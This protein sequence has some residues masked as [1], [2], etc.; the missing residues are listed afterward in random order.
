VLGVADPV[1]RSLEGHGP[2]VRRHR[3]PAQCCRW[4]SGRSW[5]MSGTETATKSAEEAAEADRFWRAFTCKSPSRKVVLTSTLTG[6]CPRRRLRWPEPAVPAAQSRR[7]CRPQRRCRRR[8]GRARPG[9]P[10]ADDRDRIG[11]GHGRPGRVGPG[12]HTQRGVSPLASRR[13]TIISGIIVRLDGP[14]PRRGNDRS[15][16]Q[17]DVYVSELTHMVGVSRGHA[18]AGTHMFQKFARSA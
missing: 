9:T 13:L 16:P 4:P 12:S 3:R 11:S 5:M 10:A 15:L 1:G 18:P 6:A 7:S 17:V 8:D 2:Q 14:P